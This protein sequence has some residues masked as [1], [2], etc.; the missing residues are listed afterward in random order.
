VLVG[1]LVGS[2]VGGGG[3]VQSGGQKAGV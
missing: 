1:R 3:S 2:F